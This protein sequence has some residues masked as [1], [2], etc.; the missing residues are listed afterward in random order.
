MA[1]VI[2]PK[3]VSYGIVELVDNGGQSPRYTIY[4]N[5]QIKEISDDYNFMIRT[6]DQKYY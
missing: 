3:R 1:T 4:V 5:G 6:F 2:K